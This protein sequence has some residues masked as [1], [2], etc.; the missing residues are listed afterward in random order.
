MILLETKG[1]ADEP[2]LQVV[3][4]SENH[5]DRDRQYRNIL[6]VRL[7]RGAARIGPTVEMKMIGISGYLCV[8]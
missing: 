6:G 4:E 2:V 8:R 5:D 7:C 1:G 3:L